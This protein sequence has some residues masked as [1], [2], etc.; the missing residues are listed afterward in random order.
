MR[1]IIG[2]DPPL[3]RGV[4]GNIVISGPSGADGEISV[5]D[6]LSAE[7]IAPSEWAARAVAAQFQHLAEIALDAG[8]GS[9]EL[10]RALLK[11]A[12]ANSVHLVRA[13]APR[14]ERVRALF[15]LYDRGVIKHAKPLPDLEHELAG[16]ND[17]SRMRDRVDA[18]LAAVNELMRPLTPRLIHF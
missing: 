17:Q 11:A 2:L 18:L 5:V 9:G 10:A 13:T 4:C 7:A 12:G 14:R 1:T 8:L 15:E 6:D 3:A 16:E